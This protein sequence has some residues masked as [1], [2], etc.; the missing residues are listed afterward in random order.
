HVYDAR[1]TGVPVAGTVLA[2]GAAGWIFGW[3]FER[4]GSLAAPMLAHLAI[5]EAGAVAAIRAKQ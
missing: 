3:L 5:N 4:S 1:A 2:T